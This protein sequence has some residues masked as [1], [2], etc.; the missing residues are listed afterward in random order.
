[1]YQ[2]LSPYHNH[3]TLLSTLFSFFLV[4]CLDLLWLMLVLLTDGRLLKIQ[5][6]TKLGIFM[7]MMTMILTK[8][9]HI[10]LHVTYA[11]LEHFYLM[12]R[13]FWGLVGGEG[14]L[15]STRL[16]I[17]IKSPITLPLHTKTLLLYVNMCTLVFSQYFI[18]TPTIS[19]SSSSWRSMLSHQTNYL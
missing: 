9:L 3:I 2:F 10:T 6:V 8:N 12:Q 17:S 7:M 5:S 4:V 1:M 14:V 19:S 18:L 16:N 15:M 13:Y 11:F